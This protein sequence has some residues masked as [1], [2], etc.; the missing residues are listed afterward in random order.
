MAVVVER[1]FGD[2]RRQRGPGKLVVLRT[3]LVDHHIED[4]VAWAD[5]ATAARKVADFAEAQQ[6][7]AW[8]RVR[9]WD[10]GGPDAA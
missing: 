4:Q 10:E 3:Q 5:V 2:R 1:R 7:R 6:R 9:S 8:K